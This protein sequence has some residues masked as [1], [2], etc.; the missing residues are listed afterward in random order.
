MFWQPLWAQAEGIAVSAPGTGLAQAGN[1]V[2]IVNI[3]TPNANGLS[4]NQF[5]DYNVDAQGLI[6]NNAI[7]RT[8]ATQLGGIIVGN[9]NLNG[10]AADIILNEVNGANPSQLRGYTEVAGKSA[11]VIVANPHGISCDG[12]G[13]IN[14]PNVT[15]STG[16]PV[17]EN[18]QL[19]RYQVD[20]GTVSIQ[21]AGLNASNVDQF[22][23]IT[24]ATKINARIQANKLDIVAGR[25]DVDA[26]T[27]TATARGGDGS[28]K[29]ELAIDS[30][31]LG[32]MYANTIRLVGTEAGVGVRL[33]GDMVAGGDIH[34][35]ANGKLDLGQASA[36][37]TLV[38]KAQG[39]DVQGPV[40][41]AKDLAITSQGDLRNQRS[42]AAGDSLRLDSAGRVLNQGIVEVGVSADG[43]RNR[44][45]DLQVTAQAVDNNGHTLAASRD[46]AINT[47]DLANQDGTLSAG[48]SARIDAQQLDNQNRG[49]VLS[50]GNL[51]VNSQTLLNG[52]GGLIAGSGALDVNSRTLINRK[53]ELSS[54]GQVTLRVAS[55]DN[56]A[57]LVT[58]GQS[59]DLQAVGLLDN[60]GG[61]V[62]S[63]QQLTASIGSLDQQGG[64]RL[65][66]DS[67][68]RLDVRHGHLDNRG[69]VINANGQLVLEHLA[70]V[71][72]RQGE[73][74]SNR[75]FSVV[76][77][78]LDNG[79]GKLLSDQAL[80]LSIAGALGNSAG[81]IS[82]QGLWIDT[83]SLLNDQRGMV[84]SQGGLGARVAG[85]L[86]NHDGN[87]SA[88]GDL[89]VAVGSLDNSAGRLH[90]QSGLRLDLN[91]GTWNNQGGLV[92]VPGQLQLLNLAAVNN[93]A[94]EISSALGFELRGDHLDN[95]GGKLKSEGGLGLVVGAGLDNRGGEVQGAD[96]R[97]G[98]GAL[99]NRNGRIQASASLH[100][101]SA[102]IDNGHGVLA[103]GSA[104]ALTATGLDN[105]FGKLISGADLTATLA[106]NLLNQSGLFSAGGN[107]QLTGADLVNH[108]GQLL[109]G[110][111]LQLGAGQLDNG[112]AGRIY[113]RDVKASVSGLSQVGGGQLYS[114]DS[115]T[116]DLNNGHL[117]NRG[118]LINAPGQLLLSNLNGVDNQG[119]EI[120]SRQAFTVAVAS[121]DNRGGKLLADQQLT[122]RIARALDNTLGLVRAAAL[123]ARVASLA[124]R[125][126]TVEARNGL[127]LTVDGALDNH[128]GR[129]SSDGTLDLAV[130][131][132]LL[133][134]GGVLGAVGTLQLNAA[135]LDN[136]LDGRIATQG[137][138]P[139]EA[140]QIDNRG[141]EISS[142]SD[143]TVN[144]G[145][146]DNSGGGRVVANGNLALTLARLDNQ[147]KG[148]ISG[149]RTVTLVA[150]QLNNSAQGSLYAKQGLSLLLREGNGAN[151]QLD[152]RH[153]VLRSD[154]D[155]GLDL[156]NLLNDSGRVSGAGNLTLTAGQGV[157][158]AGGQL[159][160]GGALTLASLSLDNSRGRI[161]AD[162]GLRVTTGGLSN[163]AGYLTSGDRLDL[164]AGQVDNLGGR[165]A[166]DKALSATLA[167]LDQHGGGQLYSASALTLDLSQ[168]LLDNSDG[169]INAVG[170]LRLRNLST[171]I[172]RSGE[173]SSEQGFSLVAEHLDNSH[174]DLLSGQAID[175]RIRQ[176]L[177]NV[178]GQIAAAGLT[179]EAASLDNHDG[180]FSSSANL[181]LTLAGAL[182]NEAGEVSGAGIS[183]I[184]AASLANGQGQVMSDGSLDLGVTG[185]LFNQGGTL[186]AGH[187]LKVAA[188]SLDNRSGGSLVSDGSLSLALSD[189]LDNQAAG[190]VLAKG[191][192]ELLVDRIDNRAGR[193]SGQ[194]SLS[195]RGTS[196]DNRG[197]V[198]RGNQDLTLRLALLDNREGLLNGAGKL[199][200]DSGE[201]LNQQGLV[202]A[203][204]QVLLH[205][206]TVNNG[207]GRIASQGDLLATFKTLDQQ[208]GEL[209]AQGG[210]SL[211]G[212][213][214][215]NRA[216]GLVGSTKALKIEV[217]SADN[218]GGEISGQQ[219][220]GVSAGQLDNS[221]GK[222]L[223]GTRL[224]M[225]VA[226][227][228]NQ[229]RGLLF[230][231]D[232]SLIGGHLDN[233][234][235]TLSGRRSLQ[236][237]LTAQP[238][239]L[240]DG[241][242]LN[243]QGK[244]VSEGALSL[245]AEQL[246]N[247]SGSIS[248][249][250][251]LVL[252]SA[253]GLLNQGG[254]VESA[255]HLSL[256]S[257]SLD[258][259]GQ[260]LIKS[261]GAASLVTGRL[262]NLLGGRIISDTTLSLRAGQVNNGGRIAS[263]GVLDARMA[264]LVQDHGEL[265]S[266]SQ[267]TLNLDQGDLSNQGLINAS[268]LV[269][270]NLG[271]VTNRGGEISSQNAFT[272]AARSLDN[273]GGKLVS[274]QGLVL[275]S[276]QGLGNSQGRI[277][278]ASLDLGSLSLD[279]RDGRISSRGSLTVN[280]RDALVNKGGTLIAAGALTV[281]SASLDNRHG[282]IAGKALVE[283]NVAT[284]DNQ[285]GQ[286]IGTDRVEVT[287]SHL[288][289][290]GG[291]LGATKALKL[292]V[293]TLDN[294]GG[295]LTGNS[296]VSVTGLSLDNSDGGVVFAAGNLALAVQR[297]IN[298]SRGQMN[299]QGV[300]LVG[301][302][303]SNSGGFI[304][305]QLPLVLKLSGD[306]DNQQGTLS[307]EST[308]A[309]TANSLDNRNG[310]LGSAGA[311]SLNLKNGLD[312]THGELVSDAS[313][314][315][316]SASLVNDQGSLSAK[317]AVDLVTGALSNRGGR[318]N[319]AQSLDLTA[320]QVSNGGSIGSLQALTAKV[321]GLDQLGGKLISDTRLSLDL[322]GGKLDNQGGLIHSAG[323]LLLGN[324][325][326]V[327]NRS[328]EISSTQ[329]FTLEARSLDN[330][331]GRVLASQDLKLVIAKT[332]SN[333]KGL[334][335]A[336]NL[337]IDAGSVDNRTGLLNSRG[338]LQLDSGGLLDNRQQ[339]LV[340][341]AG[342]LKLRSG[343]LNN[344][345]GSLLGTGSVA[346]VARTLNNS[347]SGLINSQGRLDITAEGLD[348]SNGE[349]SARGDLGLKL[350]ALSVNNGRILA[351][352]ALSLDLDGHDLSNRNGLIQA[353][354]ALNVQR[355]GVFD[356]VG[357]ELSAKQG[358]TLSANRLDNG[359]GRLIGT[360]Q[361]FLNVGSVANQNGL[362]S[363]WQGLTL[364]GGS[365]DNRNAGTLSSRSGALDVQLSGS[366][367]NSG[368]GAL[369]SQGRMDIGAASLDNSG[370]V[371]SSG[372][373]LQLNVT[374]LGNQSG[375][376]DAQ[377]WITVNGTD[378]DNSAGRIAGN[379]SLTLDLR[380]ILT[381]TGGT[382][383]SADTL[384]LKQALQV[385]NQGGKIVSRGRL[386]LNA[387]SLDNSQLGTLAAKEQVK[388]NASSILRNS[389]QGLIYSENADVRLQAAELINQHGEVQGH[390]GLLL[391]VGAGLDNRGG[392]LLAQGGNLVVQRAGSLSNQGGILASL[393]GLLD[394][395]VSGVL[396]NRRDANGKGGVVQGQQL[397]MVAGVVDNSGGR[398]AAQSGDARIRGGDLINA[399]GGLYAKGLVR[400]DS[401]GLD[402][403]AGQLA[404]GR[405]EL[406][407]GDE[408]V[409]RSGV[410]ESDTL[411]QVSAGAVDNQS[412]QLRALGT[413]G[414]SDFQIRG[415]FDNRFGRLEIG[416]TDLTLNTT[417]LSNLNG[418][419]LHGGTGNFDVSMANLA[420]SGGNL[421]TRGGLT[422]NA[423][424][425]TN[426]SVIQA[427]RLTVNVGELNQTA[428]GRLLAS[429]SFSG[430]GNNWSTAGVIASDGRFDLTLGGSLN[431]SGRTSSLGA[432]NLTLGQLT[433]GGSASLS[434]G[435]N[436]M[437]KV[438][439]LLSNAGRLT[440]AA[441]LTLEA[442]GI[443]NYGSL[444]SGQVLTASTANLVNQGGFIFSGADMALYVQNLTNREGD[445]YSLGAIRV[446]GDAQGTRAA[447]LENI[448]GTLESLG[449]FTI[450]ATTVSNK[451]V[452]FD[453]TPTLQS[454]YIG[455]RCYSCSSYMDG[456]VQI[457]PVSHLVW[458]KT[459]TY[460]AVGQVAKQSSLV[461]G[462]NLSVASETFSNSNST[463]SAAGNIDIR[464]GTFSNTGKSLN[465]YTELKYVDVGKVGWSLWKEIVQY[466]A[467][468]DAG[469]NGGIRFWN[470]AGSESMASITSGSRSIGKGEIRS[471]TN[472]ASMRLDTGLSGSSQKYGYAEFV[473]PANYASGRVDNAPAVIQGTDPF[474]TQRVENAGSNYLPS[475]VE[476]GGAVS[477]TAA[478]KITNG[479]ERA[480][481]R[482]AAGAA[483]SLDTKVAGSA[484]V[485][486]LNR[487]LPP[488]LAQQQVNPLS[489]PGF[490]LPTN[491]N[492]LFR[493]SDKA[494][495]A[496]GAAQG[497]STSGNW[498]L[499]G[500]SIDLAQREQAVPGASA[501]TL[502]LDDIG[503]LAAGAHQVAVT[504]REAAV[505][506]GNGRSIQ[507]SPVTAVD[508][509]TWQSGRTSADAITRNE[510]IG[511]QTSVADS[512]GS[513]SATG[514]G[515]GNTGPGDGQVGISQPTRPDLAPVVSQVPV[516]VPAS[517]RADVPG[518][519]AR[520]AKV[521]AP[522]STPATATAS[523]VIQRVQG[524]PDRTVPPQPHKYLVET[525]PLLTDLKQFMS[526]D[527]L[528]AGLGY[529]PDES[530]KRLGD[531]FYEQ[532]L[533]QQAVV[534]ATGQRFLAGQTSD[535]KMFKYLMDNAIA[536][537]Q[538]L[539]LA[540]GVGLTSEQ[541]AA[542]THDIV[543]LEEATINGQ[544]VLVPVV[545]LANANNRL[546]P[547]GALVAGK[548]L[549]LIAGQDLVNVG[550]LRAT[551]N[552]SASAGN[553]ILNGG[554]IQAGNRVDLLAGNDIVNKA[555]GII[556]GR[557]VSLTT[558]LGDVVNERSVT[559]HVT[560][561]ARLSARKD[562][563]DSAAR[564]EAANDM[565][566]NAGRDLLS[567]GGVLQSGRDTTLQAGRDIVLGSAEAVDSAA[568]GRTKTQSIVQ[569]GSSVTA[570]R[571]FTAV[572]G[573]DL[574]A[575]ASRIEAQRDID[576]SARG[577]VTLAS[578]A[579][580]QHASYTSKKLKT[581]E[582]H[583]R[584][585]GSELKAGGD[586]AISAG[587]DL[588]MSASRISAGDEAYLVAGGKLALLA[589]EDSDYSLY[590]KKKKG[591]FGGKYT[592]R[593]EV[594]DIR[595]VGSE[596]TTGGD[597]TLES[598]GDQWYQ[599]AK[600]QSDADLT[601]SSSGKVTFEGVKDLRQES[602]E[603]SKSSLAWNSMSGRGST[604][605]TLRQSQLLAS[606]DLLIKAADGMS[607][608]VRH[609]DQQSV[610]QAID[611]MVKADPQLAWLKDAQARGDVDWRQVK[612]VHDAYKY[613]HSG[614]G[615]GA[616]LVIAIIVTY[617]TAG[618]ASAA[619]G[620]ATGAAAGSGTALAASGT[621]TASAVA[622]GA[623][624]GSTVA[625]GWA[626]VALTSVAT[627]LASNAT[628]S[629]VN[630]RGDLGLVFKDVTS[631]DSLRGYVVSGVT[632]GLT[633]SIF[634]KMTS[635]TTQ[636]DGALPNVSKVVAEG[637]LS[638][639]E[640]IGRFGANQLLQNGT[641]AL[642][643][644]ALGGESQFDDALRTSL[645]NTF[646]AAGFNWV[647]D[648]G[649][650]IDPEFRRLSK[651]GLHAI[652]GGLAAQAAGGDFKTG[653]LAAGLN[654]SMVDTLAQQYASMAPEQRQKLLVMNA[655]LIGV[656][657]AAASGGDAKSLQ[658]GATVA[659]QSTQ[660]NWLL[661][662]E[663]ERMA[664]EKAACTSI[665]CE[666]DIAKRY[667]D[668]DVKRNEGLTQL[669]KL[670]SAACSRVV[671]TLLDD[672]PE[673]ERILQTYRH[674]G[675][676]GVSA[677][678]GR[679]IES[680]TEAMQTIASS[681]GKDSPLLVM[682]TQALLGR[683][684][685]KSSVSLGHGIGGKSEK[686]ASIG[687]KADAEAGMPYEH[688]IKP[689][690]NVDLKRASGAAYAAAD[691][692]DL[693]TPKDKHVLGG[694]SQSKARFN[695][696]DVQEI[697]DMISNGLRSN[698]AAF[699]DNPAHP[700]TFRVVIDAGRPVGVKGQT[701]VR[702]IVGADGKVMNAFPVH[703]K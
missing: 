525:N 323:P 263:N 690:S 681:L 605:E 27:L 115:L 95:R 379:G 591:S 142:V 92:T 677:F 646:A 471:W 327:S 51:G 518:V 643:D 18:G 339:G 569:S 545:Y 180:L 375:S 316:R 320:G 693:F 510:A 402:N 654:A 556:S 439:G 328:G 146:L 193:L 30:S 113:A 213:R 286:L 368:D 572:A 692:I 678:I 1:G 489:L 314:L 594:T 598:G 219:D 181:D 493:L 454:G 50:A 438:G 2:P 432:M 39:I 653:A 504:A 373:A 573:R 250:G 205:A 293:D 272:L 239:A 198:V 150:G 610:S 499:G 88:Q 360:R 634:D 492:G 31:A 244:L 165:I 435:D 615:A 67:G 300:S 371:L 255:Q 537:K 256:S 396:D 315:L 663:I 123:D 637:G 16:K 191:T 195:L 59:L 347:A 23:I 83:A 223:A 182:L 567:A 524:L 313:L 356:N 294:R 41:A 251:P 259:S 462:R 459:Y 544:K 638:S 661:H 361:V 232:V 240:L 68:L 122:L 321:T 284:I 608:D 685:S 295:E 600:L 667:N 131:G 29:Q 695:T 446:A 486:V 187:A 220:V 533:I 211:I 204:G 108:Q 597:L 333:I 279:N 404:G 662:E 128:Q 69:G 291:L 47:N 197:G 631:R 342:T 292:S 13:F 658:T 517:E 63:A 513:V 560:D 188:T 686:P 52:Q 406:A 277:S 61:Q 587:E 3:A 271:V 148:I 341:A 500:A 382:L 583:V 168:G 136:R 408:L 357:G 227:V 374:S 453:P 688:P 153:G 203:G 380:G 139:L 367:L 174:G 562:Y 442:G 288:D 530:A 303:L 32:G 79:A 552:L 550:T 652:M 407:L 309:L 534:A 366:L 665:E 230:G 110:A 565:S 163:Q 133:N 618:A 585:V 58:A 450:A 512:T 103:A 457:A 516:V 566:I 421:V 424:S 200:L 543:W 107:L 429:E 426:S 364:H 590:D 101:D 282:E 221:G 71:D 147:A 185:A 186:G 289:N 235:G 36:G 234:Q 254:V 105:A 86:N 337:R 338:D 515:T 57:G 135:G 224:D 659:A 144:G 687:A 580:E 43:S 260:G 452:D 126:G 508:N 507:V 602:H 40:H 5:K 35:D 222:L 179:A 352:Q 305:A 53:G 264:G 56:V 164:S 258:N 65:H 72:N 633:A 246:D 257:A 401:L 384:L 121:L 270:K 319:S 557:D 120:S 20:Q 539:N 154:A 433:V 632:A 73:I 98:L 365:L 416:N 340:S 679:V 675:D 66:S 348:S 458:G 332:L 563:V 218:R 460:D 617:L 668:L 301:A 670:D 26:R 253:A 70:N 549:D 104:L 344:Q 202:S 455:V 671:K 44:Q 112:T 355:V 553:D 280:A 207:K 10:R 588:A 297:V 238:A 330:D 80:T 351:E 478:S 237:R 394:V 411:L 555:G 558:L 116:L 484:P 666:R 418:V 444:G 318:L 137:N 656:F 349:V 141:G 11:H 233:T 127:N 261:Q 395:N 169:L 609:I 561:S 84:S 85:A 177:L 199:D 214:L 468:H 129:V 657:A 400:V 166:S 551:D 377:Q 691:N 370:G 481:S 651:V 409:N 451:R 189:L 684:G 145:H 363:G 482:G 577:D 24:R 175:L 427:G 574:T 538:Q 55:L 96:V 520:T 273:G 701:M 212:G 527:Y 485:I 689:N 595:H 369:V 49:R 628:I 45:G 287:S 389:A 428:E 474:L 422:L 138:L 403:S 353:G 171:V 249:A 15:L 660:Y 7:E 655:Q 21:G 228:I 623:T 217:D 423:A 143:L 475:V 650:K 33:A 604:D 8:Q 183:T 641:S 548:N 596:I 488:N 14:T 437:V 514:H 114:Q 616:Q 672:V 196:L 77:S 497:D 302:S 381:N 190:A 265:F 343:D 12:C 639:L 415:G 526:S 378:L 252:T 109:A 78:G 64:G 483:R 436:T 243:G 523:Q 522:G 593:D 156:V 372:D 106:G 388:V 466:N 100:L 206:D 298:H 647:G 317:G 496:A 703:E 215:D 622:G 22:E 335:G 172:N 329:A 472:F 495:S 599:A 674:Q 490:S 325:V 430:S 420:N 89:Q 176:A 226:K 231:Q 535:E 336:A 162:A 278:A 601:I 306:L 700:G 405:I 178:G 247:R 245:D 266:N 208:A 614:L 680:N 82:A 529:N 629:A 152:N 383:V 625:A 606:G 358:L 479:V 702:V 6:L 290:R 603:K 498:T 37:G 81:L 640:G 38:A 331:N 584:Q 359:N 540:V 449:D 310:S 99:D 417:S 480:Y 626:N 448:S 281:A 149:Q 209:V 445:I 160:A 487:Q 621:A 463:V 542:L 469:Y 296:D 694:G 354:G 17:I 194:G 4:H 559:S 93:Q 170:P 326:D 564:I 582:D 117:D 397:L 491:P 125:Q 541:V 441:N 334:I 419:V 324:L 627:G 262:D 19:S 461:A 225:T 676:A 119:G 412:G 308:L 275:R 578:A 645:A 159:L 385:A 46:L 571:D 696:S 465:G 630:N 285:S 470:A 682:I 476:A 506:D 576:I 130:A 283:V 274:D 118:G 399:G 509:G 697:R 75:A 25:N 241:H 669:C 581:Q 304:R 124:N 201:L 586:I 635:T 473:L 570:G 503:A 531:G 464:T 477:I 242:L 248:S 34:I 236:V 307:S 386:E 97:L 229:A 60:R 611:A 42:L 414:K 87:L 322:Q 607:I 431:A 391:D 312:N 644:R 345:G 74:S 501:R 613:S 167:G 390:S 161:A 612:E 619:I 393:A 410:I 151:G 91:H 624:A 173:I 276:E 192:M 9:P 649:Q 589:A 76:A 519:D 111:T 579:D 568:Y 434:A 392:K 216:G 547:N 413:A 155:L 132:Q 90:G 636:V 54:L 511:S 575:V 536:S 440:S 158:N 648:A 362:L 157:G 642:L 554:L 350:G 620:S 62:N 592:K 311:L 698:S 210:L 48:R 28:P 376:I 346:L 683:G 268:Q 267:L 699:Y 532:R 502:K 102:G 425:W 443:D 387:G 467:D 456:K 299:G 398:I 134:Q 546:A 184:R 528:L 521:T 494:A 447:L 269:L 673:M 94:G 140:T 505:I 664:A